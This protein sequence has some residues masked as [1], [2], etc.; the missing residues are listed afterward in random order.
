M[1]FIEKDPKGIAAHR[2]FKLGFLPN[3]D[4]ESEFSMKL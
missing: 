4:A 2:S 3:K 1:R